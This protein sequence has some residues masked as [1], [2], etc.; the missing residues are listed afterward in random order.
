MAVNPKGKKYYFHVF[1]LLKKLE[2]KPEF[3]VLPSKVV[4]DYVEYII[5]RWEQV[6]NRGD[7]KLV[8]KK[9]ITYENKF[10][11]PDWEKTIEKY[12]ENLDI[13]LGDKDE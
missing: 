5:K 13:L 12:Y 8:M 10:T 4:F 6:K 1:I 3:W 9:F 11:P 7:K 2:K